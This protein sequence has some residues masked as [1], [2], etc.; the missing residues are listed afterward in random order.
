MERES[1]SS[2]EI[3]ITSKGLWSAKIKV[4]DWTIDRAMKKCLLKAAE[5]EVLLNEKNN[6]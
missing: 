1:L 2:T 3:S 6:K 5:M 4:Y